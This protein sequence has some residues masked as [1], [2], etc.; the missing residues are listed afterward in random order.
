ML[1]PLAYFWIGIKAGSGPTS[2]E[3]SKGQ[4]KISRRCWR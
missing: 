1:D 4:A 3:H 2:P